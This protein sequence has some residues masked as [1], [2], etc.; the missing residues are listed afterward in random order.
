MQD[1]RNDVASETK[2]LEDKNRKLPLMTLHYRIDY[3]M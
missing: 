1:V 2:H 3:K